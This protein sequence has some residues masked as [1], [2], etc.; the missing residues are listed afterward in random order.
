MHCIYQNLDKVYSFVLSDENK[1]M[2]FSNVISSWATLRVTFAAEYEY[3]R[4]SGPTV[5]SRLT[6][7]LVVAIRLKTANCEY[8]RRRGTLFWIVFV[9]DDI[10]PGFVFCKPRIEETSY[11]FECYFSTAY[12]DYLHFSIA[13]VRFIIY[14]NICSYILMY[15]QHNIFPF[16]DWWWLLLKCKRKNSQNTFSISSIRRQVVC[17]VLGSVSAAL[18][19]VSSS[20][21]SDMSSLPPLG[22][23]SKYT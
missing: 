9:F 10:I 12:M 23:Q 11:H 7:I 5:N 2:H 22:F 20:S 8:T 19:F 6:R 4:S 18:C 17:C 16:V 21:S 15:S 1:R 13:Q 14:T 3:R